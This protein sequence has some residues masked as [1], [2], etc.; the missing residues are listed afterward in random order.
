MPISVDQNGTPIGAVP[1]VGRLLSLAFKGLCHRGLGIRLH[2]QPTR[3][4]MVPIGFASVGSVLDLDPAFRCLRPLPTS[5]L[6]LRSPQPLVA[7]VALV[8]R[9]LS[10][11]LG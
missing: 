1:Q 2:L 11:R 4:T 6:S 9:R 8:G 7:L 10:Y 3:L 5:C